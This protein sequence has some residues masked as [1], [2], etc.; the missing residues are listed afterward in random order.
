MA[1]T[2]QQQDHMLCECSAMSVQ[3]FVCLYVADG[4][5]DLISQERVVG[6]IAN[7]P[8]FSVWV[9][10]CEGEVIGLEERGVD[11]Y[12]RWLIVSHPVMQSLWEL[13]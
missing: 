1:F 10:S 3:V 9:G 8:H 11:I 2:V 12:G 4:C 5:S 7:A 6:S 13:T